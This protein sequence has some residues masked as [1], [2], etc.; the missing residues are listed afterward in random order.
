LQKLGGAAVILAT[1]PSGEAMSSLIGGLGT[2]GIF[3]IVGA[4][5][6]P[7]EVPSARPT[8]LTV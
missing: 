5:V 8:A 1:A 6:D 7:I 2:N 4:P 3:L